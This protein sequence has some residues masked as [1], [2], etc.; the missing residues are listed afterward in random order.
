MQKTFIKAV[1]IVEGSD[2]QDV[3]NHLLKLHKID[4]IDIRN[5]NGRDKLLSVT[6]SITDSKYR[7][8]KRVGIIY[9]SED[10]PKISQENLDKARK[11]LLKADP[12]KQVSFLQLPAPDQA[13]SFEAV[14]LQAI[15]ADDGV[16]ACARQY[17][18]CLEGVDHRLSTQ[19]R[20]DKALLMAW[21]AASTGENI[22]RVGIDARSHKHFDYKHD[23]FAP[24]VQFIQALVRS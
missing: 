15:D 18:T 4:G 10:Q 11:E 6:K 12:T 3:V 9:D 21:Y 19:A 16:L 24:L 14:C 8:V 5:M 2:E 20:K 17:L 7:D 22:S 23:A 1:L 13:G